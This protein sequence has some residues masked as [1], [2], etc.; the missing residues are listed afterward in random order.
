MK[1]ISKQNLIAAA[2][3]GMV[4]FT[5]ILA[6]AQTEPLGGQPPVGSTPSVP[7]LDEQVAY[8]RAFEAVVWA[9]P[10]SAIYRFRV[11]VLEVSGM[12][13][14]VVVANSGPLRQTTEAITPNT[15]TPYIAEFS[16]LRQGPLVLELPA[17]TD[18]ASLYGQIVDAWQ[19]TLADVGPSG[20]DKGA[21][22]K[23]L[24][25]PPGYNQPIPDGYFVIHSTTYR[26]GMAFRSVPAPT[27]SDAD[28][29]AY[30][31][32]LKLYPLS[33]AANPAPTKFMNLLDVPVHTL[34]FYDIRA[35]QDIK[36]IIDVEPVRPQD[37][38]MMGMLATIG[39]E[40]GKPFNPQGKLKDAM[41][42]GV[43]DAYF[44]MQ[45]LDAKLFASSLYW[46]DRHWS[47]VMV[48]D[49]KRGFEFVTDD[50]VQI[51]KRAAAWFFFTWYPK[52][53]TDHAGTVYLAPTADAD[54]NPIQSG[55]TYRL[56][57]PKDVPARQFWSLTMYDNATWSFIINPQMRNGLSSLQKD[58]MKMN[59][60]GS[61]DLYFG[62]KAPA[63]FENNWLPTMGKTP[64]L[65]FRFYAPGEAF[66]NKTFELP[67]VELVK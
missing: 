42:R 14:N 49:D 58:T 60:D 39:I 37:K 55:K 24:L 1:T 34:P 25:L 4:A 18:K 2:L 35:L 10:A 64:Y 63:G 47:F 32:T 20:L 61:V 15:V 52:L 26:I 43:K 66:W 59:D 13:D 11:G 9:M 21:G 46:P 51:D 62:P 6:G 29:Y 3:V 22:G 5:S 23:V 27:A 57:V 45:E 31:Q 30:S 17:K 65:W 41:E 40:R 7:D 67:D 54:G 50:A 33:D 38:V 16:D 8:Q 36:D 12:A 56:R 28:A 48:P 44:Y 19:V 53:L